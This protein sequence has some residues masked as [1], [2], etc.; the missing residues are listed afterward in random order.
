MYSA[1]HG[2]CHALRVRPG[3]SGQYYHGCR[4]PA[5]GTARS[6]TVH[7]N[8]GPGRTQSVDLDLGREFQGRPAAFTCSHHLLEEVHCHVQVS[9]ARACLNHG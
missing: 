3:A 5:T 6:C 8:Q 7:L 4:Q 1:V 2:M 9:G